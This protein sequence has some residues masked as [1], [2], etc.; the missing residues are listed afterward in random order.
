[1]R[2][3]SL[4]VCSCLLM[5]ATYT[6]AMQA[7]PQVVWQENF[8]NEP[9]AGCGNE[10]GNWISS[11]GFYYSLSPN[12]WPPTYTS[13]PPNLRDFTMEC[14]IKGTSDG[15]I[16]LRSHYDNNTVTGVL[17]V[18]GG[19]GRTF[20][21]F[22][23]HTLSGDAYFPQVNRAEYYPVQG[24]DIHLRIVVQG[25]HYEAYVNGSETPIT[26]LDVEG[27]PCG[28][29]G[30]Y[31]YSGQTFDNIVI[32]AEQGSCDLTGD[33]MTDLEDV[34]ILSSQWLLQEC[35]G[36]LWCHQ[37]DI[38]L[39]G[40]V[41]MDDLLLLIDHWLVSEPDIRYSQTLKIP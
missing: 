21:G 3:K 19:D 13:F 40:L 22:Y 31:S 29:V 26:T 36:R 17:L 5:V 35:Q 27:Y 28:K 14:D 37:A 25:N 32:Y 9:C 39:N 1:M 30:L 10:R 6:F 8:D 4:I 23:W 12:N 41:E 16:W 11:G 33:C 34:A 20:D 18:T 2:T 24:A 7:G 15:G 38:N